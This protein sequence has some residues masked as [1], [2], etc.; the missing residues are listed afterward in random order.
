MAF[1]NVDATCVRGSEY[2]AAAGQPLDIAT[3]WLYQ[4]ATCEPTA[5]CYSIFHE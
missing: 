2:K 4:L 1:G 5:I 3:T